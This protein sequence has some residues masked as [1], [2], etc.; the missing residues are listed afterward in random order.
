PL[1]RS[2]REGVDEPKRGRGRAP[3][4]GP[5][6]HRSPPGPLPAFAPRVLNLGPLRRALPRRRKP[7]PLLE[8]VPAG[9]VDGALLRTLGADLEAALGLQ[10]HVAPAV[11]LDEAWRDPATGLYRSIYLM[12]ALIDRRGPVRRRDVPRWTLAIA[13]AGL[14]AAG[15][16]RVFGEAE[17]NG[18]CCVVGLAPLRSGS[19]AD[20][21]V[22]RA[23]LL[24]EALH[25]LGHLAGMEHCRRTSCVMYPSL[26]IADTDLKGAAFCAVCT[27]AL[28]RLGIRKT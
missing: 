2:L 10:W 24:T 15:V 18:C 26:H 22:L 12:H 1:P 19:G 17:L 21:D 13:D 25:E 4:G 23:R 27:P 5:R 9:A 7:P 20:S 14:C 8:I 6:R 28:K 11:P 3:A 16:G